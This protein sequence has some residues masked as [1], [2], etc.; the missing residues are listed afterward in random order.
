MYTI[1]FPVSLGRYTYS[2]GDSTR[3]ENRSF[4]KQDLQSSSATIQ[5]P[6]AYNRSP[7][8]AMILINMNKMIRNINKTLTFFIYYTRIK[9]P[10]K[11]KLFSANLDRN[12]DGFL[13]STASARDKSI[14]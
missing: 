1:R 7:V 8:R 13:R 9:V 5:G 10:W 12:N 2:I 11:I 14:L 4:A 3:P 6:G